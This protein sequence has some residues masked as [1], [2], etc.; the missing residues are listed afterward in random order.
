MLITNNKTTNFYNHLISLLENSRSFYFNVAF[1]NFS[2]VQLLLDSF[3]KLQNKNIKGKILTSTYLNFTDPKALEVLQKFN[4]IELKVYDSNELSRGFHPKGYIFEFEDHY[5]SIIGSSNITA[6]AFKTNIEW[7][8]QNSFKK[9]DTFIK[10]LFKE[11][12]DLWE[13][14]FFADNKFIIDYTLYRNK[15]KPLQ[16]FSYKKAVTANM[17]QKEALKR[18][19]YF[20]T[21]NEKK[22]LAVAATGSGKTYLSALEVLNKKP[23]SLLFLVHRENILSKAKESFETIIKDKTFGFYTGNKKELNC[24]YLFATI[25]TM[26]ENYTEFSKEQFEYIIID[27]AHHIASPSYK[28]VIGYFKPLFLLGLTATP[29]RSDNENIYKFFDDNIAC[30]I[31]I[32]DA[33]HNGLVVPFHYFGISDIQQLDYENTD[34]NNIRELTKLLAVNRRVEYIV[35]KLKFYSH[36][37]EK[38]KVLGFCASKEHAFY[39]SSEFNKRGLTS[40]ALSSA[41]SISKREEY[42]KKLEDDENTLEVIFTVDIFNEGIDIPSVNT[43]LMLRPTNSPIVFIQQLG[44]GLRKYKNKEFLT[45]LDFIGNHNKAYLVALAFLGEKR[46]D[47]ESIKISLL[48]N[49]A[50]L[51][52]IHICMD[53]ISK[54]RILEQIDKEN[55]NSFK[56]LKEQYLEQKGYLGNKIPKLTDY[57][58]YEQLINPVNFIDESKSYIEFVQR[59]EKSD[60]LKSLCGDD[61]FL[62]AVRFID[63]LLPVRRV[64][65]SAIL[66]YLIDYEHIDISKAESVLKKYLKRVNSKSVVHSFEYLNQN[67]FDKAQCARYLK[68]AVYSEGKL[69]LSSEFKKVVQNIEYKKIIENS[70]EYGLLLYERDFGNIDYG[71]PFFKLYEKYNML[72]VALC[73]NFNKIHS[74]FRGSGF[75]KYGDDFFLFITIEKDKFSSGAKYI[76]DF[77]SNERFNFVSK[78]SHVQDKGDGQKLCNN[79]KF[80]VNLHIFARKSARVDKKTQKFL[81]LGKADS[82]DY[83]GNKPVK[84][85]LKLQIPLCDEIYEEFT[86]IV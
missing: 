85:E 68:T 6:S 32:N 22:A 42:I 79:K 77:I 57:L 51:S 43:V 82:L 9:S 39:M 35:E 33:L 7:N 25:Q 81:Y 17:M 11:F 67:Y 45:I 63:H 66:R 50:N 44:R 78:P 58:H 28:K 21:I 41:D 49:F 30:D 62:K 37:G 46:L 48:N 52:N 10:N 27:E 71:M 16:Q 1:I 18:L 64:Y 61:M 19:G 83:T 80:G 13:D 69:S 73:C 12:D 4:N 38:R 29:N 14:A 72:N 40:I 31:S 84:L 8:I 15:N 2:G 54:S 60:S 26:A 86:K 70:L 55:F 23:K 59:V 36:C 65:E 76:N 3:A 56:H 20:K 47:K 53:E 5:K 24:E 74:S 75:L 34:I